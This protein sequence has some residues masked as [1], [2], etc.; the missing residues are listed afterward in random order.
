MHRKMASNL[1]S[2]D[3]RN[4]YEGHVREEYRLARYIDSQVDI[5]KSI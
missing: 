5:L 2:Y 3:L 1:N 4:S